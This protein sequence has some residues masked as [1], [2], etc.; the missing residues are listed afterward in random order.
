MDL[1]SIVQPVINFCRAY[2]QFA[3][4]IVFLIAFG[5]CF[6]FISLLIPGTFF[7]VAFGAFAGAAGL[8]LLP[9]SISASIGAAFGF[10]TSYLLGVWLGPRAEHTWPFRDKP[11]VL[12]RGHAFFEKWGAPAVFIG[13]FFGPVRAIVA[14]VAGIAKMP[15]P[16]FHLA[17]IAASIVWGFAMLYGTGV[18]GEMA[19]KYLGF[20]N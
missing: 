7:F 16:P 20:L 19:N 15:Q 14:L 12:A 8:N 13:H 5:E 17:N 11:E 6:A 4:V 1:D 10:Y 2:P 9:L 18:V 3:I